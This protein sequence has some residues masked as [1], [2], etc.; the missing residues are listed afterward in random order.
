MKSLALAA[1][2]CAAAAAAQVSP[3]VQTTQLVGGT[4]AHDV[5]IWVHP[6]D[7]TQSLVFSTN[8]QGGVVSYSL[9]GGNARNYVQLGLS[10]AVD[11]RYRFPL[12]FGFNDIVFSVDINGGISMTTPN[13]DGGQL[14]SLGAVTASG[15]PPSAGALYFN[16]RTLELSAFLGSSGGLLKQFSVTDDG[17]GGVAITLVRNLTLPKAIDGLAADDRTGQLFV[18]FGSAGLFRLPADADG[19]NT[20]L[21]VDNL[22]AGHLVSPAGIA[23]RYGPG[24]SGNLI[25]TSLTG[26]NFSV[27]SLGPGFPFLT[28]FTI[29]SDAGTP[30]GVPASSGIEIVPLSLGAPFA[31]GLVLVADPQHTTNKLVQWGEI[32]SLNVPALGTS[33]TLDP[34]TSWGLRGTSDAGSNRCPIDAGTTSSDGGGLDGGPTD[35]G[36]A[37]GGPT[38]G[39]RTDGGDAGA[40][41]AG[42]T[43]AGCNSGG[44][45]GGVI[46][47]GPG[48]DFPPDPKTPCG[49]GEVNMFFPLAALGWMLRPILR[50]RRSKE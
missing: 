25:V 42:P 35:G 9:D 44:T 2:C 43:D 30:S 38:D 50:R 49:C 39:G 8:D 22:D 40:E 20:L 19:G 32:A 5:A 14:S 23:F 7:V 47:I 12:N 34:R 18:A 28:S 27:Y 41:D 29:V 36:P 31:S 11:V 24:S 26:P 16:P 6:T 46:P 21:E 37:D 45:P 33:P 17:S 3:V 4:T 13:P 15:L 48:G 1:F 10:K